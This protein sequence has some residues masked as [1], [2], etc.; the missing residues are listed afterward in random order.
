MPGRRL[1]LAAP[2][3]CAAAS[4]ALVLASVA[5]YG[6]ADKY[7]Y[8]GWA[9][10]AGGLMLAIP[11]A[12]FSLRAAGAMLAELSLPHNLDRL[13]LALGSA[14]FL[15]ATA[16]L[17]AY[18]VTI[19]RASSYEGDFNVVSGKYEPLFNVNSF[20]IASLIFTLMISAALLAATRSFYL[21]SID[22]QL[23]KVQGVDPMGA[24][25][26]DAP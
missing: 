25:M 12:F 4:L 18:A 22:H 8:P 3:A 24:L 26:K 13:K 19:G 17:I 6:A 21:P 9:P 23:H 10:T 16:V 1:I 20:L 7:G 11:L 14:A 15:L 2:L 5:A